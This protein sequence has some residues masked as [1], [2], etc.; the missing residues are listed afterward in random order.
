METENHSKGVILMLINKEAAL[1]KKEAVLVKKELRKGRLA[2]MMV[3]LKHAVGY[4]TRW[5]TEFP[6]LLPERNSMGVVIGMLCQ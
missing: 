5:E 3:L 6:W 4:K 1:L 2:V